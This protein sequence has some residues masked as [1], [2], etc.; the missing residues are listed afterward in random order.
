VIACAGRGNYPIKF[1]GTLFCVGKPDDP[2]Y[3]ICGPGFWWQNTRF[4]YYTM[5]PSGDFEMMKPLFKMYVTDLFEFWRYRTRRHTWHEGIYIPECILFWGD[6]F[7]CVY[8]WTPFEERGKD[9]LHENSLPPFAPDI[10]RP[11]HQKRGKDKLQE[12]PGHKY[13][14]VS[15]LELVYLTLDLYDYTL[16]RK[17]LDE[18]AVP[19]AEE[20]FKFF[21]QHYKKDENGK[22]V[23]YP[24]QACETWR[25]CTNPMPEVA[26]LHAIAKRLLALDKELTTSEQ[27]ARWK[28]MQQMLPPIPLREIDGVKMLA[29]AE[30]FAILE[31]RESPE[32]YAVF[33]FRVI[34]AA[35]D[36]HGWGKAAF[37]ARGFKQCI[38][39][40]SQHSINAA[41]LGVTDEAASMLRRRI[42]SRAGGR[43]FPVWYHCSVNEVPDGDN[44]GTTNITVQ[45]MLMQV[46]GKKIYLL[47]AWPKNWNVN[48]RLHAPAKT[49][50]DCQYQDGKIQQLD[51]TP[52]SRR[53]DIIIVPQKD[54]A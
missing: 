25:D 51:V 22:L 6:C 38:N 21:S 41:Y 42:H 16:D 37:D 32:L 40:W 34:T 47:P 31:N 53:K 23:M 8:G 17:V 36:T 13:E 33:P 3:R 18:I 9:K 49:V 44:G 43:R 19:L 35:N 39:S 14:W 20:A 28:T 15:T 2:D 5:C 7:N 46:D 48:F 29:P 45:S 30:K 26:G 27:R 50:I 1:N 10:G 54:V 11:L 4:P 12:C 52:K 24:S